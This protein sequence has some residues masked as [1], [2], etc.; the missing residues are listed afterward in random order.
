MLVDSLIQKR[1]EASSMLYLTCKEIEPSSC[2]PWVCF[3]MGCCVASFDGS[4]SN[5][6]NSNIKSM[7]R[8]FFCIDLLDFSYLNFQYFDY[9]KYFEYCITLKLCSCMISLNTSEGENLFVIVWFVHCNFRVRF[10]IFFVISLHRDQFLHLPR[11]HLLFASSCS[12]NKRVNY[13][14][15]CSCYHYLSFPIQLKD[16]LLWSIFLTSLFYCQTGHKKIE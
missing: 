2:I 6:I 13:F 14:D 3:G 12:Q 16:H 15:F 4:L 5:S 10:Y 7:C 1:Q 11:T 9:F 8:M